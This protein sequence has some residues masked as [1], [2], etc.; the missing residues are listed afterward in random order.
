M[1]RQ[2]H[3]I[4]LVQPPAFSNNLRTDMNPNMGLGIGY[5]AATLEREG[6]EVKVLDAFIEGW[7]RETRISSEK[8][9]VG[10]PFDE[11][12]EFIAAEA[13]DVVGVTSM[14]T[15]QRKNAHKVAYVTKKV[16][17]GIK[18]IVGGAHPTA[19]PESVLADSNVDVVVLGEGDNTIVP[20]L[21]CIEAGSSLASVDGIGYRGFDGLP[22]IQPKTKQIEDL[23]ELPFPARHLFP[24]EKY[25]GSRIKHGGYARGTGRAV[26]MITSRG[27]QY[28]CNFCTAFKVFTRMPRMRSV[29]NIVA[30]LNELVTRYGVDEIFFEDDQFIAKQRHT[31]ELLDALAGFNMMFDTPNGVSSWLLTETII[32]KMKKAGCYRINLALES[33]NQEVLKHI[34]N[35]PVKLDEVPGL[36]RLIRK[37]KMEVGTFLVVGNIAHNRVETLEEIR[38]SFR[39][40]RGIRV[41]PNV[42]YLT[43]YPG[44]EVLEIAE[45]K[46]YL[47][48]GFDWDNLCS[49]KQQLQTP[50][51]SPEELRRVVEEERVKTQLWVWLTSPRVFVSTVLEY[52]RGVPLRDPMLGIKKL[53][54]LSKDVLL[55]GMRACWAMP[56]RRQASIATARPGL[57]RLKSDEKSKAVKEKIH[58]LI[59]PEPQQLLTISRREKAPVAS[60]GESSGGVR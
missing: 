58:H 57:E 39:F 43:A 11:I 31:D 9:F 51:W 28:R 38:G 45:K 37:H 5:I 49:V 18:V 32:E 33:G 17:P 26:S 20:L 16:D 44:S 3:K 46:G 41:R 59:N 2:I 29:Q 23:D 34:I 4:L 6:Y 19:A 53:A 8:I 52:I 36:V 30:E 1:K 14:F 40:C 25:F 35:K 12:Q 22:I 7:D 54:K 60:L 27:C 13:P 15:A 47:I 24:M 10:M 55:I 50:Q 48:P 21:Q 56:S 42:S